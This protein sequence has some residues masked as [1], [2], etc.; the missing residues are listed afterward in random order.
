MKNATFKSSLFNAKV[1]LFTVMLV[2]STPVYAGVGTLRMDSGDPV[3]GQ[4]LVDRALELIS[5]VI[6]GILVIVQG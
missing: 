5:V 1:A 6:S 3:I 4:G 2:V